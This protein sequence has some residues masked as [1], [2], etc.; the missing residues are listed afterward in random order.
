MAQEPQRPPIRPKLTAADIAGL[1]SAFELLR[2][3]PDAEL[4]EYMADDLNSYWGAAA[5]F[6]GRQRLDATDMFN[7]VSRLLTLFNAAKSRGGFV[8]EP[9]RPNRLSRMVEDNEAQARM[10]G[11]R[12]HPAMQTPAV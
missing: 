4:L 1:A 7:I 8:E 11:D 9:P 6:G 12:P 3:R 2:Q 10:R 5:S